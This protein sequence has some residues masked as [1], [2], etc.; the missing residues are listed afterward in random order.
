MELGCRVIMPRLFVAD[1]QDTL[2]VELELSRQCSHGLA[3]LLGS[4][5]LLGRELPVPYREFV[6]PPSCIPH[7]IVQVLAAALENRDFLVLRS[8]E[9]VGSRAF[10]AHTRGQAG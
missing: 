10:R 3:L 9:D 6:L 1:K 5:V 2:G 7:P 8:L 4:D